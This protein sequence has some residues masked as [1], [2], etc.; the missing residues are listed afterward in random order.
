MYLL[1]AAA[2]LMGPTACGSDDSDTDE[3]A[4]TKATSAGVVGD[5]DQKQKPAAVGDTITI[6]TKETTL[7]VTVLGVVD[8]VEL[9]G[10]D[11][12]EA[13]KRFAGVRVALQNVGAKP[14]TGTPIGEAVLTDSDR[15]EHDGGT[16]VESECGGTFASDPQVAPGARKEGCIPYELDKGAEPMT[17]EFAGR[18]GFGPATA[19]WR[20]TE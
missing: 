5:N 14:Y 17:F 2:V 19:E 15:E 4:A 6:V 9:G 11:G 1:V 10:I 3:P 20:L 7:K 18:D 12:A 16:L 13:G 8:P